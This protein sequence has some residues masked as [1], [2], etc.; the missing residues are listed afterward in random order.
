M[1]QTKPKRKITFG[2]LAGVVVLQTINLDGKTFAWFDDDDRFLTTVDGIER[3]EDAVKQW[4]V[5]WFNVRPGQ[6]V[7][8]MRFN[9]DN[10]GETFVVR[11][12]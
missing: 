3:H 12:R 9:R 7:K 2:Q 1:K 10:S 6:K 4:F 11:I 5:E 8:P